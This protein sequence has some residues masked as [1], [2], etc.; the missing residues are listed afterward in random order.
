MMKFSCK[1]LTVLLALACCLPLSALA[2]GK[3]ENHLER[4][5][6][7][8]GYA[9]T[10]AAKQGVKRDFAPQTADCGQVQVCFREVLYDGQWLYAAASVSPT[11][12]NATLILPGDSESGEPLSGRYFAEKALDTRSYQAAAQEDGKQLLA[13]YVYLKEFDEMGEYFLDSYQAEETI[14]FSGAPVAGGSEPITLTWTVQLYE[15]DIQTGKYRFL[16][17]STYPM[18]IK[19]MEPY[20]ERVYRPSAGDKMPLES[21]VLIQTALGSYLKPQWRTEQ[22]RAQYRAVLTE[23]DRQEVPYGGMPSDAYALFEK[24]MT[25]TLALIDLNNDENTCFVTLAIDE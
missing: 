8:Y 11:E 13:V 12:P 5:I 20:T 4:Y 1:L 9:F 15:V 17:E 14:L 19:P 22:D 6:G 23:A 16:S 7:M 24:P 18:T 2:I 10:D 3:E 21:T 25:L